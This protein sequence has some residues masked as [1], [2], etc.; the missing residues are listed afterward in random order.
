M[1]SGLESDSA[2][3]DEQWEESPAAATTS[4]FCFELDVIGLERVSPVSLVPSPRFSRSFGIQ[5]EGRLDYYPT[6]DTTIGLTMI[7]TLQRR[8]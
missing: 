6:E 8:L 1:R 3:F 7:R 2:T 4:C 5:G